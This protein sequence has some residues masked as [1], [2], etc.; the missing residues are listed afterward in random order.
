MVDLYIP[1]KCSAT[2]RIIAANDHT[3]V[4]INIGRIDT[5]GVYTGTYDT[6]NFWSVVDANGLPLLVY[7]RITPVVPFAAVAAVTS[8][9]T[10]SRLRRRS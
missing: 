5:S 8:N 7:P 1:R 2:N 10:A 6:V 3:A 9:S 4:Q